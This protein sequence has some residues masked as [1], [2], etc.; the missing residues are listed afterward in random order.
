[1]QE[2]IWTKSP[3]G[4]IT[5][6]FDCSNSVASDDSISV[7][8]VTIY[9]SSSTDVSS[10]DDD[11]F[12]ETELRNWSNTIQERF[13]RTILTASYTDDV[14]DGGKKSVILRNFPVTVISSITVDG[15]ALG[16]SDYTLNCKS[17]IIRMKL[18]YAFIGGP[19][20]ILVSYTGGCTKAPGD[21]K[22][23]LEYYLSGRDRKALAKRS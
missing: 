16:T 18:C 5:V 10:V 4:K 20:S 2:K 8:A 21:L 7:A 23:A 6:S 1:M 15:A 11:D 19:G 13:G 9:D 3:W 17:G 12:L 22:R 14:Y